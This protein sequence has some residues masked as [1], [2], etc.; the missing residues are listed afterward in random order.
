MDIYVHCLEIEGLFLQETVE[1]LIEFS[2]GEGAMAGMGKKN[3]TRRRFHWKNKQKA[4]D[5]LPA[6]DAENPTNERQFMRDS[7]T[8][9]NEQVIDLSRIGNALSMIYGNYQILLDDYVKALEY[10]ESLR[11]NSNND[12]HDQ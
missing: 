4:P 11:V 3:K 12:G 1:H 9:T 2:G 5:H 6:T 8:M 10:I 7:Q